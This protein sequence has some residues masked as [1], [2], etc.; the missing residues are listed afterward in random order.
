MISRY[1]AIWRGALAAM[2]VAAVPILLLTTWNA[3]GSTN[4]PAAGNPL[5]AGSQVPP[6]V[7][8]IVERACQDCHS[9]RTHWPW[10][11][12]LPLLSSKLHKDVAQGRS[13]MDFSKWDQYTDSE[14]K[15]YLAAI[16]TAAQARLMPPANYAWVHREARLSDSELR[17]LTVWALAERKAISSKPRPATRA[18]SSTHATVEKGAILSMR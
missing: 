7:L 2:T 3:N 11:S 17:A 16:V 4:L 14:R 6:A 1:P 5:L 8:S 15:G 12:K 10:Y 9:A 13:F 18:V